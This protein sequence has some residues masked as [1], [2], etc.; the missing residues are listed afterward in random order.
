MFYY[1]AYIKSNNFEI[2]R[3]S[4]EDEYAHINKLREPLA[5]VLNANRR[6]DPVQRAFNKIS[7]INKSLLQ[8]LQEYTV[9]D[10]NDA[11]S[12]Y[13]FRLRKYLDNYETYIKR[14]YGETSIQFKAFKKATGDAY[15]KN[16]EYKIVYQ[17]R[18]A[19]QH[20]DNIVSNISMGIDENGARYIEAIAECNN[21]LSVFSKWKPVERQHLQTVNQIDIFR[22][23]VIAHKC[24]NEVHQR[25]L[26]TFF[27]EELYDN[28]CSIVNYAN[29]YFDKRDG[30]HFLCQKE[31]LTK[32][33]FNRPRKTLNTDSWLVTQCIK[34][35][36]IHL[37][38][39][40]PSAVV[41]Y[42]G[43]LP[44]A[45][46]SNYVIDLNEQNAQD[47]CV[48]SLVR[49]SNMDYICFTEFI[50]LDKDIDFFIAIN[51]KVPRG[52]GQEIGNRFCN[53]FKVLIG[54]QV[55]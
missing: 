30:L 53:I 38:N 23:I 32:E 12:N 18:N 15:D 51:K 33:Y 6:I 55:K 3:Q 2:L 1:L 10:L 29:E 35:L 42:K 19:D 39:N 22:Y 40:I 13:L 20:C 52:E 26:D 14:N 36:C 28:C 27:S 45:I 24:I 37:K 8:Q 16:D 44:C 31:E 48:G 25:V 17:L 47:L 7:T 54:E 11:I 4:N 9:N 5:T 34:L 21:L 50:L 41:L 43:V 46:V 49:I